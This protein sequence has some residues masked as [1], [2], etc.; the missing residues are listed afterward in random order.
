M[1]EFMTPQIL[2]PISAIKLDQIIK[3]KNHFKALEINQ[4]H[5]IR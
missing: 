3:Q 4:L 1:V 2:F 5:A